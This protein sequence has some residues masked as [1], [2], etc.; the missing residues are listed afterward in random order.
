MTTY[1]LLD[2]Y[3][4]SEYFRNSAGIC[5]NS[6]GIPDSGIFRSGKRGISGIRNCRNLR[7]RPEF[8]RNSGFRQIPFLQMALAGMPE[9]RNCQL[10]LEPWCKE[11]DCRCVASRFRGRLP[12]RDERQYI[13]GDICRHGRFLIRPF[14]VAHQSLGVTKWPVQRTVTELQMRK[15]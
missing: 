2:S 1:K 14:L 7:F 5:R 13:R 10:S 12:S 6:A 4:L 11:V 15:K 9:S 8:R 3:L